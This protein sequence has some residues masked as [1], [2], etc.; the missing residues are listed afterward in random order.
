MRTKPWIL[1]S[2]VVAGL[3]VVL[4]AGRPAEAGAPKSRILG[5]KHDFTVGGGSE[6]RATAE[7]ASCVFCHAPHNATPNVPLW[8]HAPT[9]TEFATYESSTLQAAVATPTEADGS[10]LCLS[11]HDGTIALGETVNNGSIDFVQAPGYR[12]GG[13]SEA[14]LAR[15][16]GFADDHPVAMAPLTGPEMRLPHPEDAV[17][18]DGSGKVQCTTC[19][20]PHVQDGDTVTKKF[21]VKPNDRSSIC[22]TCHT[23]SG[24]DASSHHQPASA[25]DD[26]RYSAAQGAHTGYRGVANNA[27]ES[28]HRPH[29]GGSPERLLKYPEES[30]CFKCHNGTVADANKNLQT[31]FQNKIYRHPVATTPSVHDAAEG[32]LNAAFR[33][34]ET[35]TG[36]ERHAECADCHDSHAAN[37]APAAPPAVKGVLAD[38]SGITAAGAGIAVAR[39]EYE[40]CLKCHGDSAN[41]PQASDTGG[42]NGF[43]R[44][45]ARQSD[46]GNPTRFNTRL[47]FNSTVS[48]HPVVNARGLSTGP[49]G[50]VPS[51]RAAPLGAGGA[52]L[53][54]RTLSPNSLIYCTDCHN[55]DTGVNRGVGTGAA[56][57]HASNFEH[58]LE[59]E[60][61]TN[62]PP[63]TP[64]GLLGTVP[65]STGAYALCAKCHD[66]DASIL[67]NQSFP[68]HRE[69]VVGSG[70]ACSSCHDSHGVTGGADSDG[71]SLINF[72]LSLVS[73]D[74]ASGLL[75]YRDLGSRHGECYLT[76]HGVAHSPKS[77]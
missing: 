71:S 44:N 45:P 10:K 41:K 5:S 35:S 30:T 55:S 40:V 21:L 62:A 73:P 76:C 6:I 31:D 14:N 13:D 15:G 4:F 43:G 17:K 9:T 65:Y 23:P 64:G 2:L 39:Y 36:A 37:P 63:S 60:Y 16:G 8:N 12:L 54:G 28:C 38:V 25:T 75:R 67:Q 18:L 77:Y 74:A 57:P 61:A 69:H 24:W 59:R 29:S 50:D 53:P 20:D 51:L 34:P 42:G 56:G 52:P 72:D 32:P 1:A 47:E 7:D 68:L 27:C 22:L 26:E 70:M 49:G 46:V 66:V 11:C 19:H 3:A 58:L 48:F 33:L